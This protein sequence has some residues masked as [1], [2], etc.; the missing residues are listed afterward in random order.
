[1]RRG[2]HHAPA[3]SPRCPDRS[4]APT[5]STGADHTAAQYSAKSTRLS[6]V[7]PDS[8]P[9]PRIN[10]ARAPPNMK[11]HARLLAALLAFTSLSLAQPTPPTPQLPPTLVPIL[12][13]APATGWTVS[14]TTVD[15]SRTRATSYPARLTNL[16]VRA[17]AGSGADALVAGAVVQSTGNL[18]LLVRAV[19][20][21]LR[22]YGVANPLRDPALELFRATTSAAKTAA[23]ATDAQV[24]SAYVGAFPLAVASNTSAGDA[25]LLGQAAV[26]TLTAQCR[27]ATDASGLALLEF[28][29]ATA[30]PTATSAR[31]AN[32]SSRA[33]VENGEGIVVIGFVIA[34]EGEL[35]LLLRGVGPSL[36]QFNVPGVLADP[37]IELFSGNT[38]VAANDN[39]RSDGPAAA[40]TLQDAGRAL[41]AFDLA[42]ANDAALLVTLRAGAY[43][44]H[45]RGVS[46]Q[47]GVALAEIYEAA[48]PA[49][50]FDIGRATN[51]V[52]IDL[53]RQLAA[54]SRNPN[55]A[56]S[57][58]SIE[59]ALALA[60]AGAAGETRTEMARVLRFPAD[61]APLQ[62]EFATLR[63]ALDAAA[64]KTI[65]L[66]TAR[67]SSTQRTEPLEW[68]AANRLFGQPGYPFRESFLTLMSDGFSAPLEFANFLSNPEAARL[69]VNDWVAGQTKQKILN[70]IPLGAVTSTT[71]LILVNALYL[72]APWD[73][74]F[75]NFST[76]PRA[77]HPTPSTTRNVPTMSVSGSFGYAAEE[78]LTVVTLDYL[79]SDLQFVIVLP[80]T[81]QTTET[82]AARLTP[83]HFAR[84]S[85]LGGPGRREVILA[86]PKF[87]V[88]GTTISLAAALDSL[89]MPTA[90]D[91]P[92]RS[93]NFDGIAPRRLELNDYLFIKDVFHQSF[94]AVDEAGT[95]AAAATAVIMTVPV[96]AQIPSPPYVQV[97]RPFLFAIQHRASGACLFLGRVSDPQ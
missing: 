9:V 14:P 35:R 95:E 68:R 97:D 28:Y 25:A 71:R 62:T 12:P 7:I 66:A 34:G 53:Y 19:G 60:Y 83:E 42:S 33:R 78:G 91:H 61:N 93:A 69:T 47:T 46:G 64:A 13:P 63:T 37:S 29:D 23:F 45:V 30:A 4:A 59:S 56:L 6:G 75:S 17:V 41:G 44:L 87:Q 73:I 38:L 74:P 10:Y 20:P 67:T 24:A 55:F 36:T 49:A 86:M 3:F 81:G 96:S 32:I 89:G 70:L 26:G 51:A 94:V 72:K 79:G 52:G 39:W 65:P 54:N 21:G 84:W 57:P 1:M 82:A 31:F 22:P 43:S 76:S 5:E 88:P 80:D 18:P 77:F 85:K 90:F 50:G 58:Y 92:E 40:T 27:S 11:S 16:S 15:P 8:L 2:R 48:P